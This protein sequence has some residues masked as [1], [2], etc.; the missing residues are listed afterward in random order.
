MKNLNE[1]VAD[2]SL[3]STYIPSNSQFLLLY[4]N[5]QYIVWIRKFLNSNWEHLVLEN[6]A[7]MNVVISC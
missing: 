1:N 7:F 2:T 5:P 6:I 4:F 3:C